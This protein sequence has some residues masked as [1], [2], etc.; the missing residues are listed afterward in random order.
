MNTPNLGAVPSAAEAAVRV[1]QPGSLTRITLNRPRALNA[2]TIPMLESI[3]LAIASAE[4]DGSSAILLDGAGDR[5]FCGGGDIKRMSGDGPV[6][7]EK[8][9]HTEYRTDYLVHTSKIPAVGLMDG[10]TM[11]GGIGLAG[12]AAVR[13]VTERSRLAMPE[14]KIGLV[15][16]VGGH[17]LLAQ[18]PGRLGELLAMTAGSMTA[19]DAI[20]LGFAD[21][22]M[23]SS[24]IGQ[25][26]VRLASGESPFEVAAALAE[27][28]PESTLVHARE[29]LDPIVDAALT[30]ERLAPVAAAVSVLHGL[31]R[32]GEL[33]REAARTIRAHCP[34]SV[35]LTLAQ[36][37]R[38]RAASLSLAEVLEDDLKTLLRLMPRADFIEGVRAVVIDKDGRPDWSP[39]SIEQ[40]TEDQISRILAPADPGSAAFSLG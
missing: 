33:A 14:V 22:F 1:T 35:V 3:A 2:L 27:P 24:R 5:G 13:I 10:I 4:R 38:T 26:R 16:D 30:D 15:P 29:W 25:L 28:A 37:R 31:E 40:V 32:G 11:G 18:A 36:L 12:H 34:T 9:L 23:P 17:H 7:A 21:H 6:L 39:A 19:G 20:A 8:F